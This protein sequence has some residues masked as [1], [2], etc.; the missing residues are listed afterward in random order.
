MDEEIGYDESSQSSYSSNASKE[1]VSTSSGVKS[2][3]AIAKYLFN[4][5][6]RFLTSADSGNKDEK[7][8]N[9]CHSRI[10]KI[11]KVVDQDMDIESLV[12]RHLL[13]EIFLKR[14]CI[15]ENYEPKTIQTYLKTLEHFYDFIISEGILAYDM[16]TVTSL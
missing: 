9:Q 6:Y 14:Y 12:N 2:N 3:K 10:K 5:F 1:S 16:A 13:R 11:L 15:N 7:S 8:A 4:A